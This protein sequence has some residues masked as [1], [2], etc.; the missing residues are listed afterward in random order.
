MILIVRDANKKAKGKVQDIVKDNSPNKNHSSN[1]M[2]V[3]KTK[4]ILKFGNKIQNKGIKK[5]KK[6]V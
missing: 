5:N 4:M 1:P 2:P 3:L 6:H